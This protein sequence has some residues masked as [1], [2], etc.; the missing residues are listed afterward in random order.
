MRL[1]FWQALG[2]V[3]A[4]LVATLTLIGLLY[5]WVVRPVW[6][7]IR[8][9]N[10]VADDILGEPARADRPARPSLAARVAAQTLATAA[11]SQTLAQVA[12]QVRQQGHRLDEHLTWHSAAGRANGP[13][14]AGDRAR[15][16]RGEEP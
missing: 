7:T 12:D 11:N 9:L 2:I 8:R 16:P 3:S 4:A 1:D 14:P 5:R 13:R 15:Q 6:R 10:E